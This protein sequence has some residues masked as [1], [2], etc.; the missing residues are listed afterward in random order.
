LSPAQESI[1]PAQFENPI[2]LAALVT[3]ASGIAIAAVNGLVQIVCTW[4]QT[5]S[6]KPPRRK[7]R[8]KYRKKRRRPAALV[9][10]PPLLGR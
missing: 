9:R 7:P 4:L 3:G 6:K 8:P 1:V 5:R 2:V 10:P